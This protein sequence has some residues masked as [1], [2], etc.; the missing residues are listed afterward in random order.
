MTDLEMA[1]RAL[2]AREPVPLTPI[3][4]I[5]A[6]AGDVARRRRT[7]RRR[8][9]AATAVVAVLLAGGVLRWALGTTGREHVA[10]TPS[11]IPSVSVIVPPPSS[12]TLTTVPAVPTVTAARLTRAD[13]GMAA[14][15][16]ARAGSSR[17]WLTRDGRTWQDVTPPALFTWPVEDVFAL[18]DL[19]LWALTDACGT[20]G[21]VSWRSDD[22]GHTW[23]ESAVGP[24]SCSAGST[25]HVQF[26]DPQHGWIVLFSANGPLATLVSTSD[27]GATWRAA[28]RLPEPGDVMFYTANDGYLGASSSMPFGSDLYVTHDA[29]RTWHKVVVPLDDRSW[30]NPSWS[31]IYGVPTFVDDANG[32]LPLTLA[33]EGSAAVEWWT[34]SDGGATWRLRTP[35]SA[36]LYGISGSATQPKALLT[37]VTGPH[38][39]WALTY[40]RGGTR[41]SHTEDAGRGWTATDA[42]L[43]WPYPSRFGAANA[44]VAWLLGTHLL[45]TTDGG[46]TW[47]QI[48]PPT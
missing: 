42:P 38:V 28:G 7:R 12:T 11:S 32:V 25:A 39:W 43:A 13:L 14:T 24:H 33:K 5:R 30:P 29:G 19:H 21:V 6:R 23:I 44:D 1:G 8:A 48:D 41:S 45:A 3:E 37:S 17:L 40:F 2:V 46:R 10:T 9:G 22:G 31:V 36:G 18:D 20:A 4:Q 35:P 26:V 47:H 16:D 15:R 34:T 27:G